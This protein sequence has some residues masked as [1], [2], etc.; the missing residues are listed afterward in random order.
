MAVRVGFPVDQLLGVICEPDI[1]NPIDTGVV[2]P[3]VD[4]V[5]HHDTFEVTAEEAES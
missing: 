2:A 5:P 4:R 1:R 3:T